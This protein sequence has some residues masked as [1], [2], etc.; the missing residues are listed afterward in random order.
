LCHR[1]HNIDHILDKKKNQSKRMKKIIRQL[2]KVNNEQT[3]Q[4][5]NSDENASI[6]SKAPITKQ[7]KQGVHRAGLY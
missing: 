1:S 7:A 4:N 2:K 5:L 3:T 6:D